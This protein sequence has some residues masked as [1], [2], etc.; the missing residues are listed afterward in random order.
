MLFTAVP[1]IR[2]AVATHFAYQSSFFIC[3]YYSKLGHFSQ[4][5]KISDLVLISVETM[6]F[7]AVQHHLMVNTDTRRKTMSQ[8]M[9]QILER[10]SEMFPKQNYQSRLDYYLTSKN[11][12]NV[13]DVEYWT[14]QYERNAEWR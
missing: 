11:V 13:A 14:R 10:L 9:M 12:Q 5:G 3:V 1:T 4:P 2:V 6:S 7:C 8:L